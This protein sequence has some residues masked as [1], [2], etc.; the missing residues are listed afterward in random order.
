[1]CEEESFHPGSVF[2]RID[3]E[4]KGYLLERDVER[5][6]VE[7]GREFKGSELKMLYGKMNVDQEDAGVLL[8]K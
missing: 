3:R 4:R 2:Y 6:L 7:N 5:F 8:W 1:M